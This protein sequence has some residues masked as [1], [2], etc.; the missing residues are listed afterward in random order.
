[1][2]RESY[3]ATIQEAVHP[4]V[5]QLAGIVVVQPGPDLAKGIGRLTDFYRY[6][7]ERLPVYI[8]RDS[9][10]LYVGHEHND[11]KTRGGADVLRERIL[12]YIRGVAMAE[13]NA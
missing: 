8:G 10:G 5:T 13:S 3:F 1:M 6:R 9:V 4:I 11:G 12:E 7:G 2:S